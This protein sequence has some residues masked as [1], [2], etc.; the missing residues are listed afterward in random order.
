MDY[1]KYDDI[2]LNAIARCSGIDPEEMSRDELIQVLTDL[3]TIFRDD[4][5]QE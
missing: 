3:A 5:E 4:E 2:S 1:A